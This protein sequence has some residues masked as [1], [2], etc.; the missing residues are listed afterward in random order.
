M[1]LFKNKSNNNNLLI[2]KISRNS[3]GIIVCSSHVVKYSESNKEI[4]VS[5]VEKATLYYLG[6]YYS[7][8]TIISSDIDTIIDDDVLTS[9]ED[10]VNL[11]NDGNRIV[12]VTSFSNN[13]KEYL[14]I[15]FDLID[16]ILIEQ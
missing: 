1:L 6:S 5:S 8:E 16:T 12:S 11:I 9:K 10:F 7:Q 3:K 13:N 2:Y 4:R 14:I 15:I